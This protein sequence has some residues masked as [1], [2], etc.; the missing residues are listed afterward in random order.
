MRGLGWCAIC[1]GAV[2]LSLGAATELAAD[3]GPSASRTAGAHAGLWTWSLPDTPNGTVPKQSWS[4]PGTASGGEIYV[5]GMDHVANSALYR[6]PAVGGN[7][8]Q[9]GSTLWYAGDAKA[10]SMAVGN[11]RTGEGIEKFHTQ[12]TVMNGRI[13]VGNLNY[14]VLDAG[15]LQTRGFHWYAYD[16][17]SAKFLD[18]TAGRAGGVAIPHGGLTGMVADATKG[19]LFGAVA[20]TG[21]I[22]RYNVGTR[23]STI[24]GRPASYNRPYVYPGRTLWMSSR[25]RVYFT[26]GNPSTAPSAK[27]PYTPAIFNHV[28]YWNP[29]TGTFGQERGWL[30]RDT[31][32]IDFGRCYSYPNL[33]RT[34]FLMDNVGHVYRYRETASNATWTLLGGIGQENDKTYGMTWVFQVRPDWPDRPKAYI[35]SRRGFMFEFDLTTGRATQLGNLWQLEPGLAGQ[36]LYGNTSWDNNGRFYF[37]AFPK[38]PTDPGRAKLVA[39]DPTVYLPAIR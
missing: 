14:S 27:G 32:A 10:A 9:P 5:G 29:R 33:P 28:H 4:G 26:A 11:Y 30:L 24:L 8:S 19:E 31:R 13:Y 38:L 7:A 2:A 21:Q 16:K 1:A 23:V 6:L 18:L 20:P 22:V 15:Y 36:E 17:A 25:G 34:C 3:S 39:L 37:S 35:I 12:P